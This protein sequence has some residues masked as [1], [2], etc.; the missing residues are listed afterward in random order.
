MIYMFTFTSTRS[1]WNPRHGPGALDIQ[2]WYWPQAWLSRV[3]YV[4]MFLTCFLTCECVWDRIEKL[5]KD[6]LHVNVYGI[7]LWKSVSLV[8]SYIMMLR[9]SVF[10]SGKGGYILGEGITKTSDSMRSSS[11]SKQT[12]QHCPYLEET[13]VLRLDHKKKQSTSWWLRTQIIHPAKAEIWMRNHW[14]IAW[15][16]AHFTSSEGWRESRCCSLELEGK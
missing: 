4:L 3:S 5:S 11:K 15:S 12:L 16:T 10:M 9:G 13:P 2:L 6:F 14:T 7:G 1:E 8:H